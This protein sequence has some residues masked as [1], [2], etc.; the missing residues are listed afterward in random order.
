MSGG[1]SDDAVLAIAHLERR[2]VVIDIVVKQVGGAPFDAAH[3]HQR[4]CG[5][6]QHVSHL[7]GDLGDRYAGLTFREDFRAFGNDRADI[8][9]EQL[10]RARWL[11]A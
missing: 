5:H 2:I 8:Y 10:R 3:R 9:E 1:S 11:Q 4:I 6:P 7:Q